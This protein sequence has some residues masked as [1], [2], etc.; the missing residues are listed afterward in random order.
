M[1]VVIAF[2]EYGAP[3]VLT[4]SDVPVPQPGPGQVRV[5]VRASAVNPIDLKLRSGELAGLMPVEFPFVPGQDVAGVVDEAGEG[6]GFAPGDEVFGSAHGGGYGEYALLDQPFAK[7]EE[8]S[9]ETAAAMITV[10]ET[11]YRALEEL[12]LSPG[13]TLLV[14]GA[15]GAV[16]AVAVQ[17]A[18]ARGVTVIGTAGE[19][20]FDRVGRHGATVVRYGEGWAERVRDAA[21]GTVDRV[22]DTAG[23]GVLAESIALTGDAARVVT[24]ADL[25]F[26]EHGVRF[27]GLDP[28]DH[29]PQAL[30]LLADLIAR[31]DL[32]VPVWR[33]FPLTQ[34]AQAHAEIE[35]HHNKGKVVLLP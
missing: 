24:I 29:L 1:S 10:G 20:D 5:R 31:G 27:T 30:P 32:E 25:S 28:A 16:G 8:V 6:T 7:P 14:H 4:S 3:G 26:A 22:L 12:R 18:V 11:A 35:A 34:A 9:F 2:S 17:L 23:A 13:Q 19:H 33:T 21:A 15:G